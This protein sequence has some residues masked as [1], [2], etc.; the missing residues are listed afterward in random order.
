MDL[1]FPW[2]L[3]RRLLGIERRRCR[4]RTPDPAEMGTAWG[5]EAS[6]TPENW[7]E[8]AGHSEPPSRRSKVRGATRRDTA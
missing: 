4:A 3:L 2:A 5:M 6:L 8:P 1:G 7:S